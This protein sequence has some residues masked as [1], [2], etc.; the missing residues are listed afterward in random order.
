MFNLFKKM[1]EPKKSEPVVLLAPVSGELVPMHSVNDPTFSQE[2]LGKGA[3]I[4]P[5]LGTLV[6]PADAT[7][8]MVFDTL[9]AVSLQ[10]QNGAEVILHIG[11]DTVQLNGKHFTACVKTGDSVKAG[12]PL[13]QFDIAK[14]SEDGYDTTV[15]MIV[16]NTPNFPGISCNESGSCQAGVTPVIQLS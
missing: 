3:A 8:S 13:I 7:V 11:L 15:L 14:I 2:I 12:D 1:M 16:C 9:H 6:A 10:T 4:S 5:S